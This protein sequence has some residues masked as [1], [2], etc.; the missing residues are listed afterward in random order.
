MQDELPIIEPHATPLGVESVNV[1]GGLEV[2]LE[3]GVAEGPRD[4]PSALQNA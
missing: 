3:M 4:T 1:E 2:G